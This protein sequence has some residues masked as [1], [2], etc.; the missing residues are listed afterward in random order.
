MGKRKITWD[1]MYKDFKIKFPTRSKG[2]MGFKP[3]DVGV[4]L[5]YF[6]EGKKMLFNHYT[7]DLYDFE[8]KK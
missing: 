3:H 4:I 8:S 2:V 1:D 5:L 7:G 6:P